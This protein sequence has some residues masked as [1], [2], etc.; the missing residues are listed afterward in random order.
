MVVQ[1]LFRCFFSLRFAQLP[2]RV[3]LR[4]P[5]FSQGHL[6]KPFYNPLNHNAPGKPEVG[7]KHGQSMV[8]QPGQW[9]Y[10]SSQ[11]RPHGIGSSS[12][13]RPA[14]WVFWSASL[15]RSWD[16]E[17]CQRCLHWPRSSFW[18]SKYIQNGQALISRAAGRTSSFPGQLQSAPSFCQED[19]CKPVGLIVSAFRAGGH[20]CQL[21]PGPSICL[22]CGISVFGWP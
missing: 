17:A 16:T 1:W 5:L 19:S 13:S 6:G 22:Y 15:Q 10:L 2:P 4:V 7:F 21:A 9:V 12:R 20:A 14:P 8:S 18:A 11:G 3:Y